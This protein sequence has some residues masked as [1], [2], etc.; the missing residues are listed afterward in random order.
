MRPR[1]A[2]TE[3]TRIHSARNGTAHQ[4]ARASATRRADAAAGG[5]GPA[6]GGDAGLGADPGSRDDDDASAGDVRAPPEVE[7]GADVAE[8]GLPAA[9]PEQQR[10]LDEGAGERDGEDVGGAV[11][12]T[13]VGLAG[14]RSGGEAATAGGADRERPQHVEVVRVDVLGADQAGRRRAAPL[15]DEPPEGP[16]LGGRAHRQG[17]DERLARGV[18]LVGEDDVPHG[19]TSWGGRV[20]RPDGHRYPVGRGDR[21]DDVG[22]ARPRLR[23]R[24]RLSDSER[25]SE[26][27]AASA[28]AAAEA[29]HRPRCG[30]HTRRGVGTAASL[31]D[32]ASG[33]LVGPGG[34]S[35][36]GI[37]LARRRGVSGRIAGLGGRPPRAP[38]RSMTTT[39][40][41]GSA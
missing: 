6:D 9:Q 11:V 35:T 37:R 34:G 14:A 36:A 3:V 26:S 30:L 15:V 8:E 23:S 17:P 32:A 7:V 4:G 18:G 16:V 5:R 10:P 33:V 2:S 40:S 12:L 22:E 1:A 19:A 39:S 41:G 28:P 31:V 29:R 24:R 38:V 25:L 20:Y 13:L 27:A 21:L